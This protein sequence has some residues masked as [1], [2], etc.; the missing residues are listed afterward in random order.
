M[1][2][3]ITK[4]MALLE[5]MTVRQLQ[6]RYVEVFGEPVRSRHRQYLI[7]RIAWRLQ[8][9]AE[10]GLSE[11]A[12]RRAEELAHD[13]DVRLTPPKWARLPR[14]D[15]PRHT[16]TVPVAVSKDPRL[17]SIGSQITRLYKGKTIAVT[18]LSDGFEYLGDRYRSLTAVARAVT[19]S[20]MNGFRFFGLES[21]E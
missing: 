14:T 11:R 20:H 2:L 19:G 7:R 13:A 12:M 3:N 1:K 15:P 10:G 9:N 16:T 4:E 18:V 21:K 6:E 17:P 8:A 5:G